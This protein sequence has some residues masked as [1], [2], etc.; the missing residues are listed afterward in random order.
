M[1][2]TMCGENIA[3][4]PQSMWNHLRAK[5]PQH[6][7]ALKGKGSGDQWL[8]DPGSVS[9]SAVQQLENGSASFSCVVS[10]QQMVDALCR[11]PP[12]AIAHAIA[13][14]QEAQEAV[15]GNEEDE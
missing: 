15:P 3:T 8:G 10:Y 14:L 5:H 11:A 13:A 6:Y 9:G 2:R 12:E 1:G 7:A 4:Y